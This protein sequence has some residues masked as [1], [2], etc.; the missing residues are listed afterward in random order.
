MLTC[1]SAGALAFDVSRTALA[2]TLVGLPAA[3]RTRDPWVAAAAAFGAY[4]VYDAAAV[5][6][7]LA[8]AREALRGCPGRRAS[9]AGGGAARARHRGRLARGRP[10]APGGDRARRAEPARGARLGSGAGSRRLPHGRAVGAR[11]GPALERPAR[12]GRGDARRGRHEPSPQTPSP[13]ALRTVHVHGALGVI[14]AIQGRLRDAEEHGAAG[15][16]DRRGVGVALPAAGR[17]RTPGAGDGAALPQR[18]R[19]RAERPSTGPP[20]ACGR[21]PTGSSRPRWASPT[22][23]CG[24]RTA[25]SP[26]PRRRWRGCGRRWPP[27]SPRPTCSTPATPSSPRSRW[28]AVTPSWSW[29]G[30]P[31]AAGRRASTR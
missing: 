31:P 14:A 29:R 9:R 8:E 28:C 15:A 4:G 26:A 3:L 1:T 10:G 17:P 23:G 30:S 5:R 16:A 12:A 25:T 20:P 2:G 18:V 11:H 24:C 13:N 7:H 6:D 27:G 21:C 22:P 19:C